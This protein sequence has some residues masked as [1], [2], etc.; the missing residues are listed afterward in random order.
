MKARRKKELAKF[1]R[2][3]R[4]KLIVT[5][6]TI[7]ILLVALIG[8]IMY[9]E[10][11]SGEKYEKIVLT[12]QEYDSTI[13]PY[14]RGDI[15]DAKGTV[16]A[17]SVDVYNVILDCKVLNSKEEY[18]QP[19]IEALTSCFEDLKAEDLY[20]LAEE[21]PKSQYN[22]ILRRLPYDKVQ[23]FV[24]LQNDTKNHPYI[25]G[26]WMEKEYLREYP[27]G[28]LAASVIG[29]T[30]SGNLGIGGLEDSYNDTLNGVNGREYG[31]LNSDSNFEKTIKEPVNGKTVV[32]TIDVNIQSVVE[33]KLKEFND[34]CKN[35]A[36]EGEG[37][38]NTAAIVMNPNNGEIYAMANYPTFDLNNPRD[39]SAYYSEE[40]IKA[41]SEDEQLEALNKIWQN[42]CVTQTY[43]PGSTVKPL[44]VATGLETGALTGN[45]T[46]VCDG[47]EQVGGHTIH[48]VNRSGHGLLTIEQSIMESCNDALMQM[49]YAIQ[50]E[51]LLKY[52][53]IF[54]FGQKTGIDLPG[55]ART[56]SLM[57]TLETMDDASL[58]TNS[59]G[60]VGGHTIHCVNRSGHGLLTIEQS[61]MESCNDAL[62]QMS[63]AIQKENLLKYQKIFGFGQKTG[64]DLPGEARTDSLMYTLET[65]DDASLATNSFGQNFN[66]TM[67]QMASAFSSLING[68]NY[69]KPHVVKKI[70]DENGN[71][72]EENKGELL[73][74]TL[75]KDTCNMVKQYLYKTVSEGTGK[76]AK[77]PGYSMGGK[78]GTAQKY[79]TIE[80]DGVK[81]T[82]RAQGKYLVSF[83]G[84]VP[85]ENPQVVIYVVIDE[86]N[87]ADQAH[88][89]YAQN[90]TREILKEI[91]P[92]LNIY[93]DEEY[94]QEKVVDLDIMGNPVQ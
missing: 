39:L 57:Y 35:G 11:T 52:Q 28:S 73:K 59:F 69:Y 5:F 22:K 20:K 6:L 38:K 8:R 54:G 18:L 60:Q 53:K 93:Q 30:T 45:E 21:K 51:N 15:V 44:T 24:E 80:E 72:I 79:E 68:G 84:Y 7:T 58:A 47:K 40:Q 23:K 10:V 43:E 74:Q 76:T 66:V 41:M 64:I 75:S 25:K 27:Y 36:E 3:M 9:I 12:Q 90:I 67:V 86:P 78:T 94:D 71:L 31:Y 62:M 63:Y 65:M 13:L 83:I 37:S 92:Y 82:Q 56:D 91:L 1:P 26:V 46:Y 49:S 50:K 42:F 55:E 34:A 4:K 32:S 88:S 61:I 81:K 89:S 29:Y 77:V 17:T 19:T 14:Q 85:Q 33:K 87:V 2:K 70:T 48:C 16:L